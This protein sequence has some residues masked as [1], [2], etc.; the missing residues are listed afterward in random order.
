MLETHAELETSPNQAQEQRPKR[1]L[2][3]QQQKAPNSVRCVLVHLLG[4]HLKASS[5][6]WLFGSSPCTVQKKKKTR[7]WAS[8]A[9]LGSAKLAGLRVFLLGVSEQQR[10]VPW[11]GVPL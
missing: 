3:L 7:S 1:K 4:V 5:V 11:F 6:K 2:K 8:K 9:G 10:G